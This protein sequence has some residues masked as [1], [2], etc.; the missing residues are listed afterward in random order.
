MRVALITDGVWPYVLGG[1]QKHSYFLCKYLAKNK[2]YVD[3]FHFNQ[4]AYKIELLEFFTEEERNFINSFVVDFPGGLKFP[5]HYI[6]KSYLHSKQIGKLL[7][8]SENKYD[9]IYT[10]GLTGWY[11]L[12]HLK[13]NKFS[14]A[15]IGVKFHGYEMFQKA[16]NF[17]TKIQHIFLLRYP[18]K[19]ITRRADVVFSYGGKITEII[20]L[21]GVPE[22]KIVELASGIEEQNLINTIRESDEA[23]RFVFLGR[24]E[25]RK[26]IEELNQAI[27]K[28]IELD[29]FNSKIEFHFI[30]PIPDA[31]KII[32]PIVNYHGEIRDKTLLQETL[33]DGDV[34]ICPSWSEGLPNVI[35][36]AMASGLA[37]I[38]TDVGATS[39]LVSKSNGWLLPTNE[40]YVLTEAIIEAVEC[41]N[42]ELDIKKKN[43][44][45]HVINHFSW[46]TIIQNFISK[47]LKK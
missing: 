32:H 9:F 15:T 14:T 7:L 28:I 38:A 35:L 3:L 33:C 10:K 25:R 19:K 16:P 43:A 17:I 37:V 8:Q 27:K 41:S 24:Y 22:N 21:L 18:V 40:M 4:S 36:E 13:Q 39:I 47:C 34:L 46:N 30:G 2:I 23:R 20:K 45:A 31:K 12:T 6:Y 5:G 44:L 29:K 42:D 1:M 11:L 26:G